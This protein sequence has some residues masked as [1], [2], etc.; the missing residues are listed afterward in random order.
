MP[1]ISVIMPAYN[2]EKT[3]EK[4]VRSILSQTFTD[5]ELV[6]VDDGSR[7]NTY[8]ILKSLA[9]SDSRIKLLQNNPNAG[10]SKTRNRAISESSGE[11][12]A[13]CDSDDLWAPEKLSCQLELLNTYPD[14]KLTYT[15]SAFIT[16]DGGEIGYVLGAEEKIN[17]KGL[18]KRNILS[19]SSVMVK[20]DVLIDVPFP[21]DHLH[22]DYYTWLTI[23]KKIPYAYGVDKPLLIYRLTENSRSSNAWKSTKMLYRTYRAAGL[24][25]FSTWFYLPQNLMYV[26][27]KKRKQRRSLG[28]GKSVKQ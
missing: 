14:A 17:F 18:L 3:V 2:A 27:N 20:R 6:A 12:I 21:G 8:E 24:S 13:F 22:E 23:L 26:L 25:V 28:Q 10:V 19:C 9:E 16:N 1:L 11:W 15:A 7:D 5:F 4:S